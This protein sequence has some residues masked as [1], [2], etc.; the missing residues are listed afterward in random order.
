MPRKIL[1]PAILV[2]LLAVLL[3]MLLFTVRSDRAHAAEECVARP[4]AA[5]P[6]GSHWYYRLDR[7]T[8]AHCWYLGPQGIR[9]AAADAHPV[10]SPPPLPIARPSPSGETAYASADPAEITAQHNAQGEA[11]PTFARRWL[12]APASPGALALASVGADEI[13]SRNASITGGDATEPAAAGATD[14]MPSLRPARTGADRE[15]AP[16][17]GARP[18]GLV[19]ALLVAGLA[20]IVLSERAIFRRATAR[21]IVRSDPSRRAWPGVVNTNAV[22]G[23]PR[24]RLS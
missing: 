4:G 24:Q 17:H 7:V 9:V 3:T 15:S 12:A 11:V 13:A 23:R 19:L 10:P 8:H 2:S 6:P 21:R 14:G 5:A 1:A 22:A 18:F 16:A 20:S